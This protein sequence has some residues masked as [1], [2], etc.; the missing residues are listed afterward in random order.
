LK[1]VSKLR[2]AWRLKQIRNLGDNFTFSHI[3]GYLN[4]N[5]SCAV[6]ITYISPKPFVIKKVIQL[7]I[8]DSEMARVFST[9][10]IQVLA[11]SFDV[12]IDF[13]Y[14][15]GF[16]HLQYGQ[17]KISQQK[18]IQCSLVN[19]GKY[20]TQFRISLEQEKL[21]VMFTIM[22]R[23]GT[24][25]PGKP[26]VVTFSFISTKLVNYQSAKGITL[27]VID[28][29]TKTMTA[30]LTIPFSVQTFFSSYTVTPMKRDNF[31]PVPVNQTLTHQ[32]QITNTGVFPF[33]FDIV[34]NGEVQQPKGE[35]SKVKRQPP[36][37]SSP[38]AKGKQQRRPTDK[39]LQI[40]SFTFIPSQ[41][42]I[43]PGATTT[44]D[45]E[46]VQAFPGFSES[47]IAVTI[48]DS[49]PSA[50]DGV[51]LV[52]KAQSFIPG[53]STSD[54]EQIFKGQLLCLRCDLDRMEATGFLEDELTFHFAPLI[55]QHRTTIDVFL[56]NPIP[57][58]CAVDIAVAP[59]QK[60][61]PK[62]VSPYELSEKSVD[63]P[64][65]SSKGIKLSFAPVACDKFVATFE[66][67]VR[68]GTS[69][70]T[71]CLRFNVEGIGTLPTVACATPLDDRA[72]SGVYNVNLGRTLI[73]FTRERTIAIKNDGAIPSRV[74]ITAKPSPDFELRGYDAGRDSVL[75]KGHMLNLGIVF[76]P[77]KVRSSKF[78]VAVAVVDNPKANLAFCF[79]GE[80]F[81]EDVIFEGLTDDD[82]DLNF[83]NNVVGRQQQNTFSLRNVSQSDIR[84]QW[85]SHP[86]FSFSPRVG[87]LRLGCSKTITV[88]FMADKPVRHNGVKLVCSWQ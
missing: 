77:Q 18:Q 31:G 80:G 45:M 9:K 47:P 21:A 29:Q 57:I 54:Y 82:T 17:M 87:H 38:G 33:D 74:N 12:S 62:T 15:K 76:R 44:V 36:S 6:D 70:E 39:F 30:T 73:G 8:L 78:D 64:P 5:R 61:P 27:Q 14:P 2:G 16:D 22:P 41:G 86:D 10:V 79:L 23:D 72:K 25:L 42:T 60:L 20:P 1:N 40:G 7:E 63:L 13:Q 59:K 11:E 71:R 26:Q 66:A 28:T 35:V 67:T 3:E 49:P 43:A 37:K 56:I 88:T 68:N 48:T 85:Q 83:K 32:M 50:A 46:F 84:F 55:L 51:P 69:P 65:N 58:P 81:S 19:K 4:P 24:V 75:E 52:L 34:A 53:I